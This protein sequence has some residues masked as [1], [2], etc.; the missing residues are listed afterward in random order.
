MESAF[1]NYQ[2]PGLYHL[3]DSGTTGSNPKEHYSVL[4]YHITKI[5]KNRSQLKTG[6]IPTLSEIINRTAIGYGEISVKSLGTEAQNCATFLNDTLK[7]CYNADGLY[8]GLKYYGLE[9]TPPYEI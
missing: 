3:S 4:P 6:L 8:P 7:A 5:I 9:N 1:G 2:A